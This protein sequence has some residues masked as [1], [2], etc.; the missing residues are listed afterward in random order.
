MKNLKDDEYTSIMRENEEM[1]GEYERVKFI[2]KIGN[3][4]KELTG[5]RAIDFKDN[6]HFIAKTVK[7]TYVSF[8][9]NEVLPS[10]ER[11]GVAHF[12]EPLDISSN[13][14]AKL[15]QM[16]GEK[17]KKEHEKD[18]QKS[19]EIS[20]V[21][22]SDVGYFPILKSVTSSG[23]NIDFYDK[24]KQLLDSV[25]F[26]LVKGEEYAIYSP[27][28][29][30]EIPVYSLVIDASA[31]Y[32][33]DGEDLPKH[34]FAKYYETFSALQDLEFLLDDEN[35]KEIKNIYKLDEKYTKVVGDLNRHEL[36]EMVR[37]C[38][39]D[40]SVQQAAKELRLQHGLIKPESKSKYKLS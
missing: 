36:L 17:I 27:G 29:D 7:N 35:A 12:S 3:Q 6:E 26:P 11:I 2:A 34:T 23:L 15:Q 22:V 40:L 39:E 14:S 20:E 8:S 28:D 32:S 10:F 13:P 33:N 19:Q 24:E 5:I 38:H 4:M 9:A 25:V 18:M 16:I 21:L 30:R 31:V 1:F 37:E